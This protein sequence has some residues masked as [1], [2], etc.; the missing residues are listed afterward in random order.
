MERRHWWWSGGGARPTPLILID[1]KQDPYDVTRPTNWVRLTHLSHHHTDWVMKVAV[2]K[3]FES[4]LFTFYPC[5]Y[6]FIDVLFGQINSSWCFC[7]TL[8][9]FWKP[10]EKV[11]Q[12]L[13]G[14]SIETIGEIRFK[15]HW[16]II[17]KRLRKVFLFC[18]VFYYCFHVITQK[19]KSKT[20]I[21]KPFC[22]TLSQNMN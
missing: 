11:W 10:S 19:S 20:C 16:L 21:T 14:G 4:H 3:T 15:S 5:I 22:F 8:S 18:F 9:F 13:Q 6:L 17:K 7:S 2:A 1:V 12:Q